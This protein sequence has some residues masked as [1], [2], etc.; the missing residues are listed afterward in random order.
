MLEQTNF[1][2]LKRQRLGKIKRIFWKWE[3]TLLSFSRFQ[4]FAILNWNRG[5]ILEPGTLASKV[6]R[7]AAGQRTL[8]R[9]GNLVSLAWSLFCMVLDHFNN[10]ITQLWWKK[11]ITSGE[12]FYHRKSSGRVR[13]RIW[14]SEKAKKMQE[15]NMLWIYSRDMFSHIYV[16]WVCASKPAFWIQ[17][18][19]TVNHNARIRQTAGKGNKDL[20]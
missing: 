6:L 19:C 20:M 2:R 9:I 5:E 14:K 4:T 15:G 10:I 1:R 11:N 8:L 13:N 16:Q 7:A 3:R 12:M 18:A 17:N